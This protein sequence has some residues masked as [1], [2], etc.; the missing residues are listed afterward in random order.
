MLATAAMTLVL[1]T[2]GPDVDNPYFPLPVGRQ[3]IYREGDQ[4]VEVTVT[5]RTKLIANGVVARVVRDEVTRK[6]VPVEITDDYYAQDSKGTVWYLGEATTEYEHGKPVSMEG[7]FEAGVD[8]AQAGIV[9][10]AHPK[11]G[12]RYRQEFYKGHAEDRA[13][14]VSLRERV[15]V[16]LKRYRNTLM[17][18]DSNPLEPDVLEAKFYARGVGL[19][20]AVGLS[21]DTDR[22]EL[23]RLR[24][25][26]GARTRRG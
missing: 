1:A 18:L 9:M 3:W 6:G 26:A 22:E 10:P 2:A 23:V 4:R 20:L 16:P 24:T 7:S 8:G 5:D 14:I 19:V 15:K 25:T 12:M 21:G 13:K 17:T 11:V